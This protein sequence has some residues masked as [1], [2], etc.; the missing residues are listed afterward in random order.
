LYSAG[1]FETHRLATLWELMG[2][3]EVR[4]KWFFGWRAVGDSLM[5]M[6]VAGDAMVLQGLKFAEEMGRVE[7]R[8]RSGFEERGMNEVN[9][10]ICMR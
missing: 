4:L 1:V 3:K 7:E 2:L 10:V 6:E 8:L 9:V 5:S